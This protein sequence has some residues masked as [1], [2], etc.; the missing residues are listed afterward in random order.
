MSKMSIRSKVL[1]LLVLVGLLSASVIGYISYKSAKIALTQTVYDQLTALRESKKRQTINYFNNQMATFDVF[2]N[3]QQ[4][5]DSLRLFKRSF[6]QVY[7]KDTSSQEGL[8]SFY[9]DDFLPKLSKNISGEPLLDS[10]FPQNKTVLARQI[11]FISQNPAATGFKNELITPKN[12]GND[13]N[14]ISL[15]GQTHTKYHPLFSRM[16]EKLQYY[17]IFLIEPEN[18]QIVY[19]VF[20]ETDY[21]TSLETGPYRFSGLAKAYRAVRESP[22]RG[23]VILEDFSHYAPSYNKPAAFMATPVFDGKQFIGVIAAQINIASLNAFMTSEKLWEKEG[24]GKTGEVYLVGSDSKLRT[25]SRFLLEDKEQYLNALRNAAIP[26]KTIELIENTGIAILNHPIKTSAAAQ[27]LNGN[28]GT[29]IINDYRGVEVLSAFSPIEIAGKRWAILAQKDVSEALA[30]LYDLQKQIILT[31]AGIAIVATIFSL[32]AAGIFS[33]PIQRLEEGVL[34]LSRGETDFRLPETGNDEFTSL[35]K[36]FNKMIEQINGHNTEIENKNK[37]NTRLLRTLLPNVI[38][39]RVR[40][41]EAGIAETYKNVTVLYATI[42]QFSDIMKDV[43]AEEMVALINELIDAFDDATLRHGVE[44]INTI[45]DVYLAACGLPE[46][47]LDHGRRALALAE[48]MIAITDKFNK[49]H[50][51]NLTL[52]VGLCSGE[53]DA[54]IVGTRRVVYE[55]LGESVTIARQLSV[56]TKPNTVAISGSSLAEIQAPDKFIKKG[57]FQDSSSIKSKK[58]KQPYYVAKER[59]KKVSQSVAK[60]QRRKATHG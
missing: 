59:L 58:T 39:D 31:L 18:G 13:S 11:Q 7:L 50:G 35:S 1:L 36:S 54:G 2:S 30:P 32:W 41:G 37:E 5:A 15:Y 25:T 52:S 45:G 34:R 44:R 12:I 14:D 9:M 56:L 42:G 48:D 43:S 23:T 8:Y 17:D 22:R 55:I 29:Q 10:F 28:I 20:K 4:V 49:S 21:A 33:K 51:F 47:R 46:Q 27:A 40:G 16:L 19:S 60:K 24:L 3:Q 53:V 26:K 6:D 38:A 57:V